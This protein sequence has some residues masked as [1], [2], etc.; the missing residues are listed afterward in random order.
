MIHA[1]DDVC[2]N[3]PDDNYTPTSIL[4]YHAVPYI[5]KITN[6]KNKEDLKILHRTIF[7]AVGN[8]CDR[9][10]YPTKKQVEVKLGLFIQT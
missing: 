3:H 8:F 7:S 4:K 6:W 5:H 9:A 2:A 10:S 1:Y